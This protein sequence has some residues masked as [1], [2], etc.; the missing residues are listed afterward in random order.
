VLVTTRGPDPVFPCR[1]VLQLHQHFPSTDLL[2]PLNFRPEI[3]DLSRK[4]QL[5]G[6]VEILLSLFFS[7][8][9]LLGFRRAGCFPVSPSFP[10]PFSSLRAFSPLRSPPLWRACRRRFLFSPEHLF[11][12]R[13]SVKRRIFSPDDALLWFFLFDSFFFHPPKIPLPF[14]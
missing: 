7:W 9:F 13:L 11:F 4:D 10:S 14:L 3:Q 6:S 12:P 2:L 8:L 1:E 5:H